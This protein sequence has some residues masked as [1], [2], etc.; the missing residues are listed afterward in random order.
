V[1]SAVFA[2]EAIMTFRGFAYPES[3][4]RFAPIIGEPSSPPPVAALDIRIDS[5]GSPAAILALSPVRFSAAGSIADRPSYVIEFGDNEYTTDPTAI[6][7][8]TIPGRPL[9]ARVTVI[10]RFARTSSRAQDLYCLDLAG[11]QS[12]WSSS[13]AFPQPYEPPRTL[14]FQPHRDHNVE[15]VYIHPDTSRSH[16]RGVLTGERGIRLVLD[17]GGIEFTGEI[18]T[19]VTWGS[20]SMN[21]ELKGG[22]ADGKTLRFNWHEP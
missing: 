17:G 2:D 7:P 9:V 5:Y 15:G 4:L 10:D 16:F 19:G 22:S 14:I 3:E 1:P 18:V 11:Y 6:H 8:C 13:S 12:Y 20:R 21:L